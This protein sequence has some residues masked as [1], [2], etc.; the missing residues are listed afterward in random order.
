MF[1]DWL[2]RFVAANDM[3]DPAKLHSVL[4]SRDCYCT[5]LQVREW[6]DRS[7]EP[8]YDKMRAILSALQKE[9]VT[10]DVWNDYARFSAPGSDVGPAA[11][12]PSEA[13]LE[14]LL[15]DNPRL[16]PGLET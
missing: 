1:C 3:A 5:P 7:V 4:V 2:S 11:P 15:R 6:L 13:T 12:A 9:L 8:S 14:A 16:P 10:V